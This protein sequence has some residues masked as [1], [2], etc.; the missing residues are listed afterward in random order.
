MPKPRRTFLEADELAALLDVAAAQD[1]PHRP[2]PAADLGPTTRLVGHLHAQGTTPSGIAR[3]LG[4]ARSTVS[5][6]LRRIGVEPG[7]RYAGRRVVCEILGRAGVRVGELCEL[8]IGHMRL[9]DPHGARFH[10]PDAKTEA[11][12]REVQMTPDLAEAVIEH[13]DRLRRAGHPTG[14]DD[15]LVQN[16]LGGASQRNASARSCAR[17]PPRPADTSPPVGCLRSPTPQRTRSAA[18]TSP[19]PSAPTTSTSNGSCRRSATPTRR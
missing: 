16:T 2:P 18:P 13:I 17:P 1:A 8:R 14:P 5:W 7:R 15:Y 19:S 9:H 11:G 6:H 12:I 3:R 10:I 4:V